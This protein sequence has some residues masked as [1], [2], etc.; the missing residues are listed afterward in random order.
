MQGCVYNVCV[1]SS[2]SGV[3]SF[4]LPVKEHGHRPLL[5][6]VLERDT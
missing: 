5:H 2:G 1:G 4:K 3:F 6:L